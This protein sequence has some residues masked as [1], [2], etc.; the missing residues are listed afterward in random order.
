M[1]FYNS[2][3]LYLDPIKLIQNFFIIVYKMGVFITCEMRKGIKKSGAKQPL[4]KLL[5]PLSH[6]WK[7]GAKIYAKIKFIY[8]FKKHSV[9]HRILNFHKTGMKIFSGK[10]Q[11]LHHSHFLLQ[12]GYFH[13]VIYL[14]KSAMN[15]KYFFGFDV[16]K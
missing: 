7:S 6:F 5:E 9:N 4:R 3:L 8:R 13:S 16:N 11:C 15:T 10:I 14:I 2:N 12:S 1:G